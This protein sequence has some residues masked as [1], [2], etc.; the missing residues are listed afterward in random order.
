MQLL[1]IAFTL[2]L[3]L[4]SSPRERTHVSWLCDMNGATGVLEAE[5]DTIT[6]NGEPTSPPREA[7]NEFIETGAGN[8]FY[9]GRLT[10]DDRNYVFSGENHIAEFTNTSTLE[11]FHVHLRREGNILRLTED[12]GEGKEKVYH[13]APLN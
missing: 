4:P 8:V 11:R 13:C 2:A 10:L 5:Y 6:P 7:L 3:A 9:N 12:L 1:A